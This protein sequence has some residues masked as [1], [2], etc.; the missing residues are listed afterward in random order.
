MLH[1]PPLRVAEARD[2]VYLDG[3]IPTRKVTRQ[4][5]YANTLVRSLPVVVA[6]PYVSVV[7]ADAG[8][9][10]GDLEH[11]EI[12]SRFELTLEVP[13]GEGRR[14]TFAYRT[15]WSF[16]E[17]C[18]TREC[19]GFAAMGMDKA[20]VIVVFDPTT[21]PRL[22]YSTVWAGPSDGTIRYESLLRPGVLDVFDRQKQAMKTFGHAALVDMQ[23]A[24]GTTFGIRW[25]WPD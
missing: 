5:I 24:P 1:I 11:T 12:D 22:V 21:P 14:T 6:S 10:V 4:T 2:I 7:T 25:E 17:G 8:C 18:V 13:L 20:Q 3:Q 9:T 19:R 15:A 23:V 16:P